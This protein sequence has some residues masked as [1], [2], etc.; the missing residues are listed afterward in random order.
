[1]E[2]WQERIDAV[3]A[4]LRAW[5]S[6]VA[7]EAGRL[8]GARRKGLAR[9]LPP[10]PGELEAVEREAR[11]VVGEL[12]LVEASAFVEG[13]CARFLEAGP[14]E[15]ALIRARL[16][17]CDELFGLLFAFANMS[18]TLVRTAEDVGALRLGLAAVSIDDGRAGIEAVQTALGRL[19]LAALR[20][21]VDPRPHFQAVA[22]LSNKGTA[23]GGAFMRE[24][25]AE[26]DQSVFFE[27]EVAP[28]R[29]G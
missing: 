22:E 8:R 23:G 3:E 29:A 19:W 13:V 6:A 21:G 1:M 10:R 20:A 9:L 18:P 5:R 24:T 15:R 11:K 16:G 17:A 14:Q 25:L 12:A 2:K 7:D 28:R 26:F 27:R 4:G